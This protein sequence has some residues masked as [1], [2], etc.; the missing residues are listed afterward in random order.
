[1][2]T[3]RT[4]PPV[5]EDADAVLRALLTTAINVAGVPA[6]AMPIHTPASAVPASLQLVGPARGE[7]QL[8]A[9]GR[10]IEA[11]TG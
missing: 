6:L 11:A 2:P 10:R 5:L 9:A 7:E 3:L 8:L 1:M 4:F